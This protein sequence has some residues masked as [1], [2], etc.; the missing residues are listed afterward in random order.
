MACQ[1]SDHGRGRSGVWS[2]VTLAGRL[3]DRVRELARQCGTDPPL[4][5]NGSRLSKLSVVA[6]KGH[7]G[8]T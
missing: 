1:G 4:F 2:L 6:G 7:S 3:C 8:F 5:A